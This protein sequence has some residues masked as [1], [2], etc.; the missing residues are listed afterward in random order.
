MFCAG[1]MCAEDAVLACEHGVDAIWVSNHGARQVDTSP[2]TIDMLPEIVRA[3]NKFQRDR[4]DKHKLSKTTSEIETSTNIVDNQ[5]CCSSSDICVEI[6]VDGGVMRG[7]D[8]FKALACGATAVFVGRPVL[9]GLAHSGE[10]GVF[11][12]LK[13]LRDELVLAMQLSGCPSIAHIR[14][15]FV[16]TSTPIMGRIEL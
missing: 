4:D 9:W 15:S 13:L 11:N 6:Y 14:P 1:I 10:D 5:I 8:V 7:T 12:V 16:R 3:I 2:A